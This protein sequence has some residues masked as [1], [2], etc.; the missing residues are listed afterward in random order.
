V[1][2]PANKDNKDFKAMQ[3]FLNGAGGSTS[4]KGGLWYKIFDNGS[5]F[6]K[7]PSAEKEKTEQTPLPIPK[8][9][10]SQPLPTVENVKKSSEETVIESL[11]PEDLKNMLMFT[12]QGEFTTIKPR[13][14]L[15][16]ENFAKIASVVRNA[17]GEYISAGKESHF[18]IK[19]K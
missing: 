15:G 7:V 2:S 1:D 16:S 5:I 14:F 17:G 9:T 18:R 8:P 3:T 19:T 12:E 6:E 13:Q 11:F 10:E 4:S